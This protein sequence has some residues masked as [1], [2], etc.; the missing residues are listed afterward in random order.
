MNENINDNGSKP[1]KP[2]P[3][4]WVIILLAVVIVV[5]V[6]AGL[7]NKRTGAEATPAEATSAE[8]TSVEATSV[9]ATS[10]EATSA[11]ATSAVESGSS[12]FADLH[13]TDFDG[14][15]VDSSVFSGHSLTMVNIWATYCSPC[16]G[17]MST[18]ND[19]NEKYKDRGFQV[20]GICCDL[21]DEN[22]DVQSTQMTSA[23]QI[24]S[25]TG[26]S[27]MQLIPDKNLMNEYIYKNVSAVPTSLFIDENGNII[28]SVLGANEEDAWSEMIE[29]HLDKVSK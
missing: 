24:L 11:E 16:I 26:A 4:I 17:E 6:Y 14:N 27:Y 13:V 28:D 7:G 25:D 15:E 22:G 2:H 3:V 23:Q 19:L 20:I 5:I 8:V 12:E 18:L 10:A 21:V 1:N 9:E 29:A